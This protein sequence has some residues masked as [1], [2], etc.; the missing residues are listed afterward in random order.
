M[1]TNPPA[2]PK[3]TA[4][5]LLDSIS[6]VGGYV[7]LAVQ[8]GEVLVPIGKALVSKIKNAATG[9][10]TIDYQLLVSED[11]A[12]LQL[13]DTES[14]ADIAAIN[15]ELVRQGAQPIP[16]PTAPAPPTPPASS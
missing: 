16:V 14:L 6:A 5:T 3:A 4:A 15:T 13:I 12:T 8:V 7:G 9:V 11:D 2:K 1:S 10:T